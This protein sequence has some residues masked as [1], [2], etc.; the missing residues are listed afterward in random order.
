MAFD[1]STITGYVKENEKQ[2][3]GKAVIKGRTAS[4]INKQTGVKGSAYL[5][6]LTADPTL[7]A[8]GCGWNAAGTTSVTRR[9]IKTGLIKVNQ[10]FCDKDLIGTAFEYDVK[11]AVGDK[12]IPFSEDFIAQNIKGIQKKLEETIWQGD[13][14]AASDTHLKRFDGFIKIISGASGVVNATHSTPK[15]LT[16]DAK[17]CI[18]AIVAAIPNDI[19]DVEDL[20]IFVGY[21]V[22]RAYVAQLQAANLFHYTADM[23]GSMELLI[24]GTN[25]KLYGVS[26]L[27]GTKKA[28]A[29]SLSNF[30][31]G[32]D[33]TGD[34]EKFLFWYSE[35][36]SEYRMKVEF[37][38]GV[39]VAFPDMVVKY[40]GA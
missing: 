19:I 30:Y 33:M 22:F 15:S 4:L 31:I 1:V 7:A 27:N 37:N 13:V 40:L 26:G 28:Y 39:Q 18:E 6:L 24:P 14:D 12:N 35:D 29:S 5:N 36:N 10:P 9:Q 38:A 23:N 11:V 32:M 21:E 8:G 25:V 16:T 34:E 20:G 17:A 2:L 3:I